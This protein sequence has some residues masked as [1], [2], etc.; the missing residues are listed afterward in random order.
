MPLAFFASMVAFM[1]GWE[2]SVSA[3]CS[4]ATMR[5]KT[6]Q[7]LT[8]ERYQ[9]P[10]QPKKQEPNFR[11]LP[12]EPNNATNKTRFVSFFVIIIECWATHR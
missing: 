1:R 12:I 8:A 9:S 10:L 3:R 2:V 11:S 6:F 4:G 7:R 5:E